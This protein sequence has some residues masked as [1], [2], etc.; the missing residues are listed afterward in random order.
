MYCY[1]EF[2]LGGP[3][4]DISAYGQEHFSPQKD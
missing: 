1:M 2:F 3:I 4:A